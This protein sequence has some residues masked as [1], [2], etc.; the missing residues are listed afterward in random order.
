MDYADANQANES[1]TVLSELIDFIEDY[2]LSQS[3]SAKTNYVADDYLF[4]GYDKNLLLANYPDWPD[5]TDL[6]TLRHFTITEKSD[7][8][9]YTLYYESVLADGRINQNTTFVKNSNGQW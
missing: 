8:G 4:N 9:V 3:R 6:V 5:T 1:K 2:W 7:A